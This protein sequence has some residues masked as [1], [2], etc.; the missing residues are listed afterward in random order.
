MNS[1]NFTQFTAAKFGRLDWFQQ[2]YTA[3]TLPDLM[4]PNLDGE[5][6]HEFACEYGSLDVLQWLVEESGQEIDLCFDNRSFTLNLAI[7]RNDLPIVQ[8]LIEESGQYIDPT[9]DDSRSLQIAIRYRYTELTKYLTSIIQVIESLGLEESYVFVDR[10]Y[11][12]GREQVASEFN[13]KVITKS[14]IYSA[15]AA[16]PSE[17]IEQA[18]KNFEESRIQQLF[19]FCTQQNQS[20]EK[21]SSITS[22]KL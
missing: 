3:G 14:Q 16:L 5:F 12:F 2:Q 11:N 4:K 17:I 20:L 15:L 6:A 22:I 1:S 8:Y 21:S 10:L 18:N 19:T 9:E 7:H 13:D